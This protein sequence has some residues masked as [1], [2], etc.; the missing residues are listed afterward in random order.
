MTLS[1][2]ILPAATISCA[3][4]E[5]PPGKGCWWQNGYFWY[6]LFA[7]G[8]G[9]GW[10]TL[11]GQLPC[12]PLC[13]HLSPPLSL[14][15]QRGFWTLAWSCG[16]WSPLRVCCCFWRLFCWP[17]MSWSRTDCFCPLWPDLKP[18]RIKAE[19]QMKTILVISFHTSSVFWDFSLHY[20]VQMKPYQGPAL[21]LGQFF[22]CFYGGLKGTR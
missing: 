5:E 12:A 13:L 19:P 17:V 22:A 1:F 15:L 2:V 3:S 9:L 14:M 10:W 4:T 16:F 18:K 20:F 7:L 21:L 8:R 11:R 6:V